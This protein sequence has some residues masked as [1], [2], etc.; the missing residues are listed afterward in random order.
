MPRTSS[1][2]VG[3]DR[4]RPSWD[5][6]GTYLWLGPVGAAS[7]IDS[8]WDSTFGGDLAIVRVRERDR[9]SAVGFDIGGSLWTERG[10]GRIWLDALAGTRLAGRVYG[11]TAG[12]LVELSDFAHPRFGGS[13]GVWAFFGITPFARIGVVDELGP[14]VDVGVHI[15]LPVLRR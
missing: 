9:L 1:P 4:F 14:F 6:D 8:D 3:P 2:A 12:P 10:G 5:L 13:V 11:V 15:A 7:T